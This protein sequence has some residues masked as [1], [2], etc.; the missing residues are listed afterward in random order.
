MGAVLQVARLFGRL[1]RGGLNV[2]L[3]NTCDSFQWISH[4]SGVFIFGLF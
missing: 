3:A 1:W 2:D 4:T